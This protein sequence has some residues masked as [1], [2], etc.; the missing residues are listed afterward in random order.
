[1]LFGG[2]IG[3]SKK[4][5]GLWFFGSDSEGRNLLEWVSINAVNVS[6]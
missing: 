2:L 4:H 3:C 5:K 6:K 1:M